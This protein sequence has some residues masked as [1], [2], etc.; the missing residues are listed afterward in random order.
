MREELGPNIC[1]YSESELKEALAK[2]PPVRYYVRHG[3]GEEPGHIGLS[4]R[5]EGRVRLRWDQDYGAAEGVRERRRR[6]W[7]EVDEI[8]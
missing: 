2:R 1:A 7:N 3:S 8:S 5:S 6:S 4:T